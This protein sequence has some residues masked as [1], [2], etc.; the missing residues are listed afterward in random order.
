M[1]TVEEFAR[2][3]RGVRKGP[4]DWSALCPAHDDRNPSLTFRADAR[5]IRFHCHA[6]CSRASVL[7][8][9][10]LEESDVFEPDDSRNR[11]ASIERTYA[12]RDENGKVLY[13]VVR[14]FPKGFYQRRPATPLDPPGDV[15]RDPDGG[16]W[17]KGLKGPDGKPVRR[18]LYRLP[19]V[20]EAVAARRMVIVVE[21]EKDADAL[22]GLGVVATTSPQGAGKWND[23][24]AQPLVNAARIVVCPDN[25]PPPTNPSDKGYPGQ[26]HVADVVRSLQK[27][28]IPSERI[29]VVEF[30]GCKDAAD[31]V[32]AG[33]TQDALCD[34][35]NSAATGQAWLDAWDARL[36]SGPAV[37]ASVAVATPPNG[38]PRPVVTVGG[39]LALLTDRVVKAIVE[40]CGEQP[41]LY[42]S[43]DGSMVLAVRRGAAGPAIRQL[44]DDSLRILLARLIRWE[45]FNPRSGTMDP[46]A[47]PD[48]VVKSLRADPPA[49]LPTLMRIVT[50]PVVGR[51]G[52]F[53]TTPGYHP[54][55]M[56]FYAPDD[57][58]TVPPVP[59]VPTLE[60]VAVARDTF[61]LPIGDFS[62]TSD[63]ERAHAVAA[64]LLPFVR[65]LI[66]GPTPMHLVTK[67]TA[68][69]GGTL[70]CDVISLVTTGQSAPVGTEIPND[71]EGRKRL[72]ALFL[73]GE[74]IVLLDNIKEIVQGSVLA[75]ALTSEWW[76][77]RFLGQ[78]RIVRVPVRCLWLATGNNP[79]ALH[80]MVR[81]IVRIR[82]DTGLERPA[83][84]PREAFR[85]PD[86]KGWVREHRGELVH[87]ALTLVRAWQRA[88]APAGKRNLGSYEA[89]SAIVGGILDVAGIPG[90]LSNL[91][92]FR[93]E[94][95]VE[96]DANRSFVT[97]WHDKFGGTVVGVSEL[98]P[99]ATADLNLGDGTERS[100]KTRLGR[101]LGRLRDRVVVCYRVVRAGKD[102]RAGTVRWRLEDAPEPA[103]VPDPNAD[104]ADVRRRASGE[105]LQDASAESGV[106]FEVSADVA[107]VISAPCTRS[108]AGAHEAWDPGV[109]VCDVCESDSTI[110]GD[111][112]K[113]GRHGVD[114]TSAEGLHVC[115]RSEGSGH[116]PQGDPSPGWCKR[117]GRVVRYGQGAERLADGGIV[118]GDCA[119]PEDVR[120]GS[121]PIDDP[122]DAA[123]E[124]GT[125]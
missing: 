103:P 67:P 46:V 48:H 25:D 93:G 88:G 89:W 32:A 79:S 31:W 7:A 99:M 60:E 47:P 101:H 63:S 18:V 76:M 8:A 65:E 40:T 91:D 112:E 5:G 6:G 96:E 10:N 33:G 105:G 106:G 90:F 21:G 4:R 97:A 37:P 110:D 2:R 55:S 9:M 121:M 124:T 78:S 15:T 53:L 77:D 11:R 95:D 43:A 82:I 1:V 34:L 109:E 52:A 123:F 85:F 20:N 86:L 83:D 36:G 108:C 117:C 59:D 87:A 29:R 39:D 61:L 111:W 30:P 73:A 51:D 125:L 66:T 115:G 16:K 118:C 68:G 45:K 57:G 3:L 80:E 56:T 35:V 122:D 28:G 19:E 116:E 71:D 100:Q 54:G 84:R 49:V 104:V 94:S 72:T 64:M 70:L 119:S 81:R 12:Y 23:S 120:E 42:R 50:A 14:L 107:D 102:G 27:A 92:E 22:S 24:F 74:P 44:N 75:A 114:Q 98:L 26:R 69:S 38:D 41:E 17:I 13:Q 58:F 62:F 113:A